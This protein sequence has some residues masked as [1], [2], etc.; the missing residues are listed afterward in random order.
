MI[1]DVRAPLATLQ[2]IDQQLE[3]ATDL[4]DRSRLIDK[5]KRVAQPIRHLV[6]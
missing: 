3:T 2:L 6:V 5:A 4:V 1:D